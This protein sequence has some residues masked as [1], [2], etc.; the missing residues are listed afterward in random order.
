MRYRPRMPWDWLAQLGAGGLTIRTYAE[1][2]CSARD[3]QMVRKSCAKR[4]C[5]P[6]VASGIIDMTAHVVVLLTVSTLHL[7]VQDPRCDGPDTTRYG[8]VIPSWRRVL[9]VWLGS[10]G[11]RRFDDRRRSNRLSPRGH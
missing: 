7:V 1:N 2:M 9:G 4:S 11:A 6:A 3:W 10:Q 5:F 8:G